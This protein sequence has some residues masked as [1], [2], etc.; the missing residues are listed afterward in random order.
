MICYRGGIVRVDV[1]TLKER[2]DNDRF[3]TNSGDCY[4]AHVEPVEKLKE[5][6]NN[7]NRID[8]LC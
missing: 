2:K 7:D 6:Q 3:T 5:I 1:S 4:K 8:D